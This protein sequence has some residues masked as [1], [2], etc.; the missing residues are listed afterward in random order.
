MGVRHRGCP[1]CLGPAPGFHGP[2]DPL[3]EAG[4]LG[5]DPVLPFACTSFSPADD[6]SDEIGVLEAGDVGAPTVPLAGV[7]WV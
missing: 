7:L 1:L 4:D 2:I 3:K 5:V 6:A